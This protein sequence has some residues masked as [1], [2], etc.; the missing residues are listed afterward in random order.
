MLN[1]GAIHLGD[2]RLQIFNRS[3]AGENINS[4]YSLPSSL[5]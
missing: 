5:V 4:K 2:A 3:G 1:T